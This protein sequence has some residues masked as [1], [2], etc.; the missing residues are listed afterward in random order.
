MGEEGF[1]KVFQSISSFSQKGVRNESSKEI[2]FFL[3]FFLSF[4]L[5]SA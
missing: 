1:Q 4:H 3:S 2:S 5:V